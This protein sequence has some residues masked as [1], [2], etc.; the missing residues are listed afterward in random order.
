MIKFIATICF[1][2]SFLAF[3]LGTLGL[4]RFP[5]PYTRIHGVGI[6]DTLGVGF[7]GIG[8]LLLSP[9]WILRFKLIFILILFWIINPTMSHLI[10]KAGVMYGARP[11]KTTRMRKE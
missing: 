10:A 1:I 5:D 8:L 7:M 4:F 11:T 6:G 2:G 3:S 9:S